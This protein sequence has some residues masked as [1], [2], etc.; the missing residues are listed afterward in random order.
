[1]KE[2]FSM[3]KLEEL[4]NAIKIVHVKDIRE[5]AK[6]RGLSREFN[7]YSRMLEKYKNRRTM[8]EEFMDHKIYTK[9][10]KEVLNPYFSEV[11]CST[12]ISFNGKPHCTQDEHKT[13][14]NAF[15]TIAKFFVYQYQS[16]TGEVCTNEEHF[17]T[18]VICNLAG[19][20]TTIDEIKW[21]F[22]FMFKPMNNISAKEL[23]K[24]ELQQRRMKLLGI[25]DKMFNQICESMSVRDKNVQ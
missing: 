23:R 20:L 15:E 16:D 2:L 25:D 4:Y 14:V 11:I 8:K 6:E 19:G 3:E 12:L 17:F 1:M 18:N 24:H 13:I 5:F 7:E 21:F 9:V 10:Y 22:E